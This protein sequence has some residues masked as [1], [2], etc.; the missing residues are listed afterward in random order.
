MRTVQRACALLF[1]TLG[2]IAATSPRA[3]ACDE[4]VAVSLRDVD[5]DHDLDLVVTA[6]PSRTILR[7]WLNDGYGHFRDADS[8]VQ[9]PDAPQ[10][11]GERRHD[12]DA[13]ADSTPRR[14]DEGVRAGHVARV[15]V[16][17][18]G[19]LSVCDRARASLVYAPRLGSRAPPVDGR[20]I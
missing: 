10:A 5:H 6:L 4:T 9:R 2:I 17:R 19:R 16:E 11:D 12:A 7:V 20:R 13:A 14:T 3:F 1:F 15:A 8:P 18:V